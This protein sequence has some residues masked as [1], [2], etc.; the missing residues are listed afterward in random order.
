M[1][2]LLEIKKKLNRKKPNFIRSD[3]HKKKR[4]GKNWRHPKGHHNKMRLCKAGHPGLI[5]VGY[6][7]PVAVRGL[8]I[9]GL[10]KVLVHNLKELEKLDSKKECALIANIGARKKV[11]IVK[12]AAKRK[13]IIFNV[14][15][16]E[17]FL[18]GVEE[19]LKKRKQDKE[20]AEQEKKSKEKKKEAKPKE[21]KKEEKELTPEE[22]EEQERKEKENLIIKKQ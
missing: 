11:E 1:N 12:E 13:I 2:N 21:E 22:K 8:E 20:K 7:M 10:K 14:K 15:N 4:L 18:K 3:A 9:S 17:A 6:R 19:S 16:P 5:E